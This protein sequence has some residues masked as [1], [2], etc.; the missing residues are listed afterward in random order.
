MIFAEYLVDFL[1]EKGYLQVEH[2]E[3]Y[4]DEA[5]GWSIAVLG[6]LTQLALGSEA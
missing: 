1:H 6:F 3:T 4:I 5:I 2:K